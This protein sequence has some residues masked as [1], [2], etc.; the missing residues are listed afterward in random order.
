MSR[1]G[2]SIGKD[3]PAELDKES[4]VVPTIGIRRAVAHICPAIGHVFLG[5]DRADGA[6][7]RPGSTR[8]TTCT[9][10]C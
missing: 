6:D 3:I 8:C 10:R 1:A 7:V 4:V 9:P 2:H 5:V